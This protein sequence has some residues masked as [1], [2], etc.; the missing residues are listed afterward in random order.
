MSVSIL[1][2]VVDCHDPHLQADFWASVLGYEVRRRNPDEYQVRDPGGHKSLYFMKVPEP[3]TVKIR[4]HL[5]LVS[6]EPMEAAVERLVAAGANQVEVRQDPDSFDNPDTWTVMLDP[7]GN[8]F[9]VSAA[10]TLTGWA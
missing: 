10:S 5:D 8:E 9:C 3:K 6:D 7:E 4:L 2:V 1:S